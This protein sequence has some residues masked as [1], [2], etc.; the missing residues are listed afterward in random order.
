MDYQKMDEQAVIEA[1]LDGAGRAATE[2]I[3][4]LRGV[5]YCLDKERDI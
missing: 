3:G 4:E 2:R 5:N 1:I